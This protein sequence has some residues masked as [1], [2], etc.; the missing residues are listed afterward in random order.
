MCLGPATTWLPASQPWAQGSLCSEDPRTGYNTRR[1]FP[2]EAGL[3]GDQKEPGTIGLGGPWWLTAKW[4]QAG[5]ML[6]W[7]IAPWSNSGGWDEQW[8]KSGYSKCPQKQKPVVGWA[9]I[10]PGLQFSLTP[11]RGGEPSPCARHIIPRTWLGPAKSRNWCNTMFLVWMT[12]ANSLA[13]M[14]KR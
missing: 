9:L 14:V 2:K 8:K 3:G 5:R 12:E 10:S 13:T 7:G 1:G 4:Q 11:G 6:G